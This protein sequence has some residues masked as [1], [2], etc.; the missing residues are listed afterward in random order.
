MACARHTAVLADRPRQLKVT[1]VLDY[2]PFLPAKGHT[3]KR[4]DATKR[5]SAATASVSGSSG[6]AFISLCTRNH[7]STSFASVSASPEAAKNR[8]RVKNFVFARAEGVRAPLSGVS[9]SKNR[10]DLGIMLRHG[11]RHGYQPRSS[12]EP[13]DSELDESD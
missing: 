11:H 8:S 9:R 1:K 13:N 2:Y 4:R 10:E 7:R 5:M 6:S 3:G 12:T